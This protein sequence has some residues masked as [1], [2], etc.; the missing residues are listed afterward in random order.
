MSTYVPPSVYER[1]C[2]VERVVDGDTLHLVADMGCDL[3]LRMIVRLYGV[4]APEMS[5]DAGHAAKAFVE[6]WV[7]AYGPVFSLRT[8]K[9]KREKFGRYLADLMPLGTAPTSLC[10]ALLATGN[11]VFYLP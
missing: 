3:T 10:T 6:Q 1:R 9:D 5:T 4:N 7:T 2:T 11:A 8:V